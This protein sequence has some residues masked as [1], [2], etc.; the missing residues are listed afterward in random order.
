MLRESE[1]RAQSSQLNSRVGLCHQFKA[2]ACSKLRTATVMPGVGCGAPV[3]PSCSA[4]MSSDL[5][6]SIFTGFRHVRDLSA[7]GK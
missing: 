1:L 3:S 5:V 6:A 4:R 7:C 2:A